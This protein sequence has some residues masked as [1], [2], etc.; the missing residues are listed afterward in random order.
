[1]R[2]VTEHYRLRPGSVRV[3]WAV[4]G[5]LGPL[6]VVWPVLADDGQTEATMT[7]DGDILVVAFGADRRRFRAPG[8]SRVQMEEQRLACRNGW[9]RLAVAEFPCGTTPVIGIYDR[10]DGG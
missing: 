4:E 8:A 5:H 1:V 2:A 9:A 7:I 6:R 3:E 10:E